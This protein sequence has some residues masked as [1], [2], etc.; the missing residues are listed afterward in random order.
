MKSLLLIAPPGVGKTEF[1]G[2]V[3]SVSTCETIRVA[4]AEPHVTVP[5]GPGL[6]LVDDI[7]RALGGELTVDRICA[8]A[9]LVEVLHLDGVTSVLTASA[10]SRDVM[11]AITG[12]VPL[13]VP[14]GP[15]RHCRVDASL[16][17][18]LTVSLTSDARSFRWQVAPT[19][20]AR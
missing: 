19:P 16:D 3:A 9:R 6:V 10:M 20:H 17:C 12:I 13:C 2:T 8:A 1:L 18:G 11:D 4:G 7:E 15:G 14:V 5:R